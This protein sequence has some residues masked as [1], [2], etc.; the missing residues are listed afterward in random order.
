MTTASRSSSGQ[1]PVYGGSIHTHNYPSGEFTHSHD[2]NHG[3]PCILAG[4]PDSSSSAERVCGV[5]RR[6]EHHHWRSLDEVAFCCDGK[7]MARADGSEHDGTD[8][9]PLVRLASSLPLWRDTAGYTYMEVGPDQYICLGV[10][11]LRACTDK[12]PPISRAEAEAAGGTLVR[13]V[14]DHG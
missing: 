11:L 12:W 9:E 6:H 8:G 10:Q 13:L 5:T 3:R 4:Q 14:A 7:G 2:S 1:V